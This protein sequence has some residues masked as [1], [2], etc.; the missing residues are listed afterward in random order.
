MTKKLPAVNPKWLF[1]RS[2]E[3]GSLPTTPPEVFL[4]EGQAQSLCSLSQ[5]DLK[6]GTLASIIAQADLTVE[7]FIELL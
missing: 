4:E 6:P 5:Q 3:L 1:A 7:E 2:S